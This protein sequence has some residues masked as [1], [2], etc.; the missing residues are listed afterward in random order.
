MKIKIIALF[1]AFVLGPLVPVHAEAWPV[2][3]VQQLK[4][5]VEV[6]V[7]AK[8]S[9]VTADDYCNFLN[10]VA[11]SDPLS[12]Y[13]EEMEFIERSGEDGRYSYAVAKG[14]TDLPMNYLSWQDAAYYYD[15]KENAASIFKVNFCEAPNKCFTACDPFLKSNR[16]S[17]W[18]AQAGEDFNVKQE[19]SSTTSIVGE[20]VAVLGAVALVCYL[21][22]ACS[23]CY[24]DSTQQERQTQ[25]RSTIVSAQET[26]RLEALR[27]AQ[28]EA[29]RHQQ[30]L[31]SAQV[32]L[33]QKEEER[34]IEEKNLTASRIQEEEYLLF[35]QQREGDLNDLLTRTNILKTITVVR[36]LSQRITT[37]R[38]TASGLKQNA[39]TELEHLKKNRDDEKIKRLLLMAQNKEEAT[40]LFQQEA[41]RILNTRQEQREKVI[42]RSLPP[43]SNPLILHQ[44][45]L[46]QKVASLQ[47]KAQVTVNMDDPYYTS[48]QQTL[49]FLEHSTTTPVSFKNKQT[50]MIQDLLAHADSSSSTSTSDEASNQQAEEDSESDDETIWRESRSRDEIIAAEKARF[51]QEINQL[52]TTVLAEE[53]AERQAGVLPTLQQWRQG[54]LDWWYSGSPAKK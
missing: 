11:S 14:K 43:T 32:H 20:S 8:D 34:G 9:S 7:E 29:Q 35:L 31:E 2:A 54:A 45:E 18:S 26:A 10:A 42:P 21:N 49:G 33:I 3:T 47:Q 6:E 39:L 12:L 1:V 24:R 41:Q 48:I 25:G 22:P 13:D 15:W 44:R 53:E 4:L 50:A 23:N 27:L 17:S 5:K 37:E 46:N 36:E 19:M 52:R 28:E 30:S 40:M 51:Q 38:G 16:L